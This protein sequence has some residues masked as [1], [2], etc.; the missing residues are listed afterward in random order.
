MVFCV[1]YEGK[2]ICSQVNKSMAASAFQ[3]HYDSDI[4]VFTFGTTVN[5][6]ALFTILFHQALEVKTWVCI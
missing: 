2:T 5:T 1:I 6:V 4:G 3:A